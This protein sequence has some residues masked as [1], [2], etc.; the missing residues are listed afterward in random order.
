[1]SILFD[2]SVLV[3]VFYG[4]HQHH[5]ASAKCFQAA[6]KADFCARRSLGELY[7]TL[8]GLP[9]RPRISGLDGIKIVDQVR[10]R[11]SL[12]TLADD[13]YFAALDAA[14]RSTVGAAIYDLF[15]AHCALKAQVST[16]LTWNVQHFIRFGAEIAQLVKT[17]LEI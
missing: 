11:L 13:E 16:L 2:S 14:S 9:V 10:G 4:D 6:G 17:P 15:I 3:A 12:A 8:T 7:A 5:E 1:M